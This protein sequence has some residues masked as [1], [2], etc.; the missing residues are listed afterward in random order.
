[1]NHSRCEYTEESCFLHPLK[2]WYGVKL[3]QWYDLGYDSPR[4]GISDF[5]CASA[6]KAKAEGGGGCFSGP[7]LFV[8]VE[9]APKTCRSFSP[10]PYVLPPCL[11]LSSTTTNNLKI[12]Q[13]TYF[14]IWVNVCMS[15]KKVPYKKVLLWVNFEGPISGLLD[16][17]ICWWW[18]WCWWLWRGWWWW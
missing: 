14:Y 15:D 3:I 16:W 4:R 7:G 8:A 17:V 2:E 5:I 12:L 9:S 6:K 18:C 1:M 13:T 10:S 11:I